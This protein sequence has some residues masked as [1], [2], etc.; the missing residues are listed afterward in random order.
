[1]LFN[2]SEFQFRKMERVL[3][4]GWRMVSVLMLL[5]HPFKN[6]EDGKF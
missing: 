6:G 3:G 1:M 5:D 4:I 2:V